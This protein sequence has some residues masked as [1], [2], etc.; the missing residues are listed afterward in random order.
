MEGWDF[1]CTV[2]TDL[3]PQGSMTDP[4]PFP[5]SE[6]H[7]RV[8]EWLNR[9][10]SAPGCL[11]GWCCALGVFIGF[12]SLL[13][14]PTEFDAAL[15]VYST[16]AIA[17]GHLACS[18]VHVT[19]FHVPP[20]GDP[21]TLIAPFYPL[22]SGTVLAITR[23]A[24]FAG[25]PTSSQLGPHCSTAI[26]AMFRWSA[27]SDAIQATVRLGYFSWLFVLVGAVALLRAV[28]RGRT[29]WEPLTL[30]ALAILT[31]LTQCITQ[32]FHPQDIIAIG[33]ALGS[34]ACMKRGRWEWTGALMALAFVT[35]Q[36]VLLL[37]VPMFILIP[38]SKRPR[39]VLAGVATSAIIVLPFIVLTS[40]R[41]LRYALIGSSVTTSLPQADPW[42]SGLHGVLLVLVT[43]VPPI[44]IAA[45]LAWWAQRRLGARIME[46]VPLLSLLATCL[47]LRLVFEVTL[48][49]YYYAAAIVFLVLLEVARGRIRGAAITWYAVVV[50]AYNPLPLGFVNNPVEWALKGHEVMPTIF[51][52]VVAVL[53]VSDALRRRVRWYLVVAEV[54]VGLTLVKWPWNHGILRHL[55]PLWFWQVF[56]VPPLLWL[57]L[58]P[59]IAAI[60]ER[61]HSSMDSAPEATESATS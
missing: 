39:T 20:I 29:Y 57:T 1:E 10:L 3:Y 12:T 28:G 59:L 4:T 46:P 48:F 32:F 34:V 14:G 18:Y 30:I 42:L 22:F 24:N 25:F 47:A 45:L 13:G 49:A 54:L 15:S 55:E 37:A 9:P 23:L 27:H 7:S 52:A 2:P 16:W 38:S 44:A 35:N 50:L 58:S 19:R 26:V 61:R 11:I 36:F 6:T 17:N 53:I 41:A 33:F 21:F 8:V 5:S 56:L 43:R 51:F 40:G 60:N 31:P